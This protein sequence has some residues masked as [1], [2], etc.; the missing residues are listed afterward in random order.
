M[1]GQPTRGTDRKQLDDNIP[2]WPLTMNMTS[3]D[4]TKRKEGAWE[5]Y[6]K[7]TQQEFYPYFSV[8]YVPADQVDETETYIPAL[9]EFHK[10]QS[11][12]PNYFQTFTSKP[13]STATFNT[14]EVLAHVF[15][16]DSTAQRFIR[17]V[18]LTRILRL[19][20]YL[21]LVGHARK[22]FMYD[23]RTNNFYWPYVAN[24]VY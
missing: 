17:A 2:V 19:C 22:R 21:L 8:L 1:T 4:E 7:P 24:E 18:L 13:S 5:N 15:Q 12:D 23:T 3:T 20:Y 6:K 16:V 9:C 11:F 10:A 14:E